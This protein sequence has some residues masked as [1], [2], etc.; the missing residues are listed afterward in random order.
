[1]GEGDIYKTAF[2]IHLVHYKFKVIPFGLTNAPGTFQS[3]MNHVFKAYLRKFVLVLFDNILVYSATM[4]DHVKYLRLVLGILRKEQLFAKLSKCS[5]GQYKVEYLGHVIIGKGVSTE[6]SK[7]EAMANWPT[8]KSIKDRRG[9]LG[10]TGYY[11]RFV[12]SYGVIS[13]P[14][15]NL[16]KKNAFH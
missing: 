10:L 6:P 5:F 7:I 3:L 16:L 11:R 15:A 4:N 9:F 8:P 1:M 12:K 2:R 14:L 13:K